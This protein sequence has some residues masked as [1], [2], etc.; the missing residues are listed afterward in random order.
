MNKNYLALLRELERELRSRIVEGDEIARRRTRR[1]NK[2]PTHEEQVRL[3]ELARE[4]A[5]YEEA[6][7]RA[8]KR[9]WGY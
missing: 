9:V 8:R 3:G 4:I 1:A 2:K 5:A 6:V 7:R